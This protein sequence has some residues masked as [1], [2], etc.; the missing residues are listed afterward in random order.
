VVGVLTIGVLLGLS[1]CTSEVESTA[2]SVDVLET[3]APAVATTG[4]E[5]RLTVDP[6]DFTYHGPVSCDLASCS[7]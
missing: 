5:V 4:S 7:V 1:S 3:G 2:T 6:T